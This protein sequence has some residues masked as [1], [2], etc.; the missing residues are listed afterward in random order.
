MKNIILFIL[1][2]FAAGNL[3]SQFSIGLKS[4][5]NFSKVRY[6]D[7]AIQQS[8]G[9]TSV[10]NRVST[11]EGLIFELFMGKV[12]AIQSEITFSPKGFTY[13]QPVLQGF[14]KFYYSQIEIGGK[15]DIKIDSKTRYYLLVSPYVA[16]WM[17]GKK[18]QTDLKTGDVF[19][20]KFVFTGI[21]GGWDFEYNR[22]DAGLIL[23]AGLKRKNKK[24]DFVVWNFKY[25]FGMVPNSKQI[26]VSTLNRVISLNLAYLFEL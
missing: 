15:V 10:N 4:G 5:I 20:S 25:E 18:M 14:Q 11:N 21:D 8:F 26:A 23:S 7:K 13:I 3:F 19:E 22:L 24:G 16:Y 1:F 2:L 9:K 6:E 17:W 12:L